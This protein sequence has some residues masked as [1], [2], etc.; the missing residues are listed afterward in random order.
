MVMLAFLP[1]ALVESFAGLMRAK[2][3]KSR[4]VEDVLRSLGSPSCSS[5]VAD[6]ARRSEHRSKTGR[7]LVGGSE[8]TEIAC[9]SQELSGQVDA[10]L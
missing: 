10:T 6:S 7:E 2:H 5:L 4:A 8:V 3:A 1:F 9:L